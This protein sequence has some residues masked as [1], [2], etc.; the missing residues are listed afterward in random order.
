M[1]PLQNLRR[2]SV[3]GVPHARNEATYSV[4]A[5]ACVRPAAF[6]GL[7]RTD[8]AARLDD[9]A[10]A[11]AAVAGSTDPRIGPLVVLENSGADPEAFLARVLDLLPGRNAARGIEVVS[12]QAPDR[13][14][15]LHYGYSE[16]QTIDQLMEHSTLLGPRFIKVTGRYRFPA[17]SPLLG[18]VPAGSGFFCDSQDLPAIPGRREQ[19]T[20]NASIFIADRRF[21]DAR[22][23]HLYRRMRQEYRFTHVENI[24]FDALIAEHHRSGEVTLRFPVPCDAVGVGGNGGALDGGKTRQ[25]LRALARRYFPGLWL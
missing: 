3:V 18:H 24:I 17:L 11:L 14:P 2:A 5:T 12:H 13:V 9:Y 25:R 15:G 6:P 4:L 19:R 20:I 10:G 1:L 22:V 16:F 7:A 23:R 8:P 21:Y